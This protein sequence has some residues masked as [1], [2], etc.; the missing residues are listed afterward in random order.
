MNTTNEYEDDMIFFQCSQ[1]V[2]C[3]NKYFMANFINARNNKP[4]LLINKLAIWINIYIKIKM[5]L[6]FV[7]SEGKA[8]SCINSSCYP[9]NY[10][11]FLVY[12]AVHTVHQIKYY[13]QKGWNINNWQE[14][15]V[16]L[17]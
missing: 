14:H 15:T 6:K 1:W 17:A 9:F 10:L 2:F 7:I 16:D 3:N 5:L 8:V 4:A 12:R 11:L 13:A